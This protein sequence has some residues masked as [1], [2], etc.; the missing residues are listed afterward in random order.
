ME[1]TSETLAPEGV[2]KSIS[3]RSGHYQPDHSFTN[4]FINELTTR[5]V[6]DADKIPL[7]GF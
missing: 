3:N 5:G 6:K 1:G 2:I 4:Q 7:N